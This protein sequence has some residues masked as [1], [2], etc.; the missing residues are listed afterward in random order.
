[1]KVKIMSAKTLPINNMPDQSTAISPSIPVLAGLTASGKSALALE[2]A[3]HFPLEIVTADAMQVYQG[4]DIGTA[5][6]S[7]AEQQRV[8]HHVIDIVSPADSFSVSQWTTT[9]EACISEIKARHNLP[10]V[11]GGTGFYIHALQRGLPTVP[12]ADMQVQQ[13][14][15]QRFEQEGIDI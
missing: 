3:Q 12:A 8:P 7:Q 15:W 6:P 2:L 1:M 14:L 10:L 5:K 9:A 13:P 4:M 11:V